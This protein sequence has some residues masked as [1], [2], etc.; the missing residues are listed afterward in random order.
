[1]GLLQSVRSLLHEAFVKTLVDG[2]VFPA[3]T[4]VC[5]PV[6]A[7]MMSMIMPMRMMPITMP[8]TMPVTM[9]NLLVLFG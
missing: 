7:V 3:F 2:A 9:L 6:F 8:V 4:S 1:M 5:E